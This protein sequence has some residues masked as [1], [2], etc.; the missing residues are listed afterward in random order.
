MNALQWN[1]NSFISQTSLNV[2]VSI[3]C[4]HLYTVSLLILVTGILANMSTFSFPCVSNLTEFYGTA[5]ILL[6]VLMKRYCCGGMRA[7]VLSA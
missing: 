3:V 7:V 2:F 1:E 6:P 5:L 4:H